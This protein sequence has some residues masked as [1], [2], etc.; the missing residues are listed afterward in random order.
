MPR[1]RLQLQHVLSRCQ[2]AQAKRG[3][4]Q[5]A[6][7]QPACA[8]QTRQMSSANVRKP[9]SSKGTRRLSFLVIGHRPHWAPT[10]CGGSKSSSPK[11]S[12][13]LKP[14]RAWT[15]TSQHTWATFMTGSAGRIAA[16]FEI[17]SGL[18]QATGTKKPVQHRKRLP[19]INSNNMNRKGVDHSR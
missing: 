12:A 3:I 17:E 8:R 1:Y 6:S 15:Y 2:N 4:L 10:S 5:Q 16:G 19:S 7:C 14:C 9:S 11:I 13:R 18:S